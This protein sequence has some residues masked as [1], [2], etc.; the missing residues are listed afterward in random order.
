MAKP[1][2]KTAGSNDEA[3]TTLRQWWDD[4]GKFVGAGLVFAIAGFGGWEGWNYYLDRHAA[5]A[6]EAYAA[7]AEA[8]ASA[9]VDD[10]LPELPLGDYID[11]PYSAFMYL[12]R[13]QSFIKRGELAAA[14][15]DLQWVAENA[16]QPMLSELAYIR[17][18][19]V[20]VALG[21][22][23]RALNVFDAVPLSESMRRYAEQV[24][25]DA[26]LKS[27]DPD[28]AL[29]AYTSAWQDARVKAEFLRLKIESFGQAV[30]PPP[31]Q[32]TPQ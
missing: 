3:F 31:P 24:R 29:K 5:D 8:L 12:Q 13:A 22:T 28:G 19:R 9:D 15:D 21:D 2:L 7:F 10:E 20:L 18:M 4:N 25:G 23:D 14:A 6:A 27:N 30:S 11:T 1:P 16:I 32:N 26:L 17:L